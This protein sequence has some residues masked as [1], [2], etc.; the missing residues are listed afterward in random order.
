MRH[1]EQSHLATTVLGNDTLVACCAEYERRLTALGLLPDRERKTTRRR[2]LGA[3]LLVLVGVSAAKIVVALS[4]G[5]TNVLFLAVLTLVASV[6]AMTIAMP[7][8]TSR[9]RAL[10]ADLRRL[11]ARLRER[12][13]RLAPGGASADA[14]LLAAVFGIAALPTAFAYAQALYPKAASTNSSWSSSCGSSC[15]LLVRWGRRRWGV[16]WLRRWRRRLMRAR[17]RVGLG[18]R[19]ELAAG[20]LANLERIDVVEVIADDHVGAGWRPLRAL[21]TLAAQVPLVLHG[22]SLGLASAAPVDGRR[23]DGLARVVGTVQPERGPSTWP[24][25][26]AADSS[27]ATWQRRRGGRP[28]SRG[29]RPTS[30][31]PVRSSAARR[32]WRTSP[33]SSTR[34]AAIATSR[35]GSARRWR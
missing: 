5:R 25:C 33:R 3:A 4:R 26:G 18:W 29:W 30:R 32:P 13:P 2:L 24:S 7:R 6:A 17:D 15:G 9:G 16:R 34:L 10:L 20:I 1:F 14:A 21:R 8:L 19:P 12:A 22:V 27:S 35:P 31:A 28:R 11:F 23:L